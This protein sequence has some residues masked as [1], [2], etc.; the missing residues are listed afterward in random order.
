VYWTWLPD[1]VTVRGDSVTL[2]READVAPEVRRFGMV[3]AKKNDEYVEYV[4]VNEFWERE[5][6]Q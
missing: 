3:L 2:L 6:F 1:N 5:S 4:V